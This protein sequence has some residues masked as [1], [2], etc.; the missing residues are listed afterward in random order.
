MANTIICPGCGNALPAT[1]K[2]CLHCGTAIQMQQPIYQM[3]YQNQ[4]QA[5]M[6]NNAYNPNLIQCPACFNMMG[7]YANTCP[8]CGTPRPIRQANPMLLDALA[9]LAI[10]IAIVGY[11]CGY[12]V[13]SYG[14]MLILLIIYWIYYSIISGNPDIDASKVKQSLNVIT[15]LF[16]LMFCIG[17]VI[18]M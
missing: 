11:S 8:F 6:Q 18:I 17:F 5:P 15:I 2:K 1:V 9:V 14:I 4:Q 7:R 16:I 10:F 13:M 3:P 12:W